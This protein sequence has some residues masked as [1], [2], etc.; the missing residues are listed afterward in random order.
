MVPLVQIQFLNKQ[1]INTGFR[2][3]L[4]PYLERLAIV[5]KIQRN[6]TVVDMKRQAAEL[7]TP[8]NRN[9]SIKTIYLISFSTPPSQNTSI[10]HMFCITMFVVI[11][12][13]NNT[14]RTSRLATSHPS[15]LTHRQPS[16]ASSGS[17][18]AR[19]AS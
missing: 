4:Y 15:L 11:E 10:R 8:R 2:V 5:L 12:R 17:S 13:K 18:V 9:P 16:P 14:A 7:Q 19:S 6:V 3:D 1:V